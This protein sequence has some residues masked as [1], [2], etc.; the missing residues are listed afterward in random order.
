MPGLISH[1]L[2][3]GGSGGATEPIS[4]EL[5]L[6]GIRSLK[7]LATITIGDFVWECKMP[8][9]IGNG[10]V[11]FGSY[12]NRK[13]LRYY[14]W[15]PFLINNRYA[16]LCP[17]SDYYPNSYVWWETED[18]K[19]HSID[20]YDKYRVSGIGYT[21]QSGYGFINPE[22]N[23]SL[24][25][26]KTYSLDGEIS[27]PYERYLGNVTVGFNNSYTVIKITD[28][29]IEEQVEFETSYLDAEALNEPI[30]NF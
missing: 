14:H 20:L 23:Y 29:S 6:D 7:N 25:A 28:M 16:F 8:V 5:S 17:Y 26:N 15:M 10:R 22:I 11:D 9:V 24:Y 3:Y 27:A 12:N 30:Y 4:I 1:A 21:K 13:E 18:G 2:S 19:H